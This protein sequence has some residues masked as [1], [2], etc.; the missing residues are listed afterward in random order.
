MYDEIDIKNGDDIPEDKGA[1][2]DDALKFACIDYENYGKLIK[3]WSHADNMAS[4]LEAKKA[5][6]ASKYK[7]VTN[8]AER[9]Q[10]E[11]IHKREMIQN[12]VMKASF[13]VMLEPSRLNEGQDLED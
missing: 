10:K 3:M 9:E 13:L 5:S 8:E 7:N 1:D 6:I 2:R 12:V 11:E 4:W